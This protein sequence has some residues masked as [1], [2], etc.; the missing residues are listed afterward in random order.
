V[1]PAVS[2]EAVTAWAA[3]LCVWA[4]AA[5]D[6]PEHPEE[7]PKACSPCAQAIERALDWLASRQQPDGGFEAGNGAEVAATAMAG[8]AFVAGG[9]TESEGKHARRVGRCRD[10]VVKA[11]EDP[12]VDMYYWN[13]AYA[14][15]FLAELCRLKPSASL[16]AALRKSVTKLEAGQARDG[17]WGHGKGALRDKLRQAKYP[18]TITAATALCFGALTHAKEAGV[19]ASDSG[20][21]RALAYLQGVTEGGAPG[22]SAEAKAF[23][24]RGQTAARAAALLCFVKP[25]DDPFPASLRK[26]ALDNF[27]AL[28]ASTEDPH[29]YGNYALAAIGMH[30]GGPEAWNRTRG[31]RDQILKSQTKD[32]GWKAPEVPDRAYGGPAFFTA[33]YAIFLAAPLERLPMSRR[34]R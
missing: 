17:G 32:G 24:P 27:A 11:L 2:G 30:L 10:Y 22:Y 25:S 13:H 28:S 4:A 23:A 29:P 3:I 1:D 21:Q 26:H 6:P 20:L 8:L 19:K 16:K 34:A 12:F 15:I 18:E 33:S 31:L 9:S 7:C 5:Q 14:A